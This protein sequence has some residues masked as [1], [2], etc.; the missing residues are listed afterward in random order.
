MK[1]QKMWKNQIKLDD[2][3]KHQKKVWVGIREIGTVEKVGQHKF[4]IVGTHL[5]LGTN[6][7]STYFMSRLIIKNMKKAKQFRWFIETS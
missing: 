6:E 7:T 2:S 4:L 5:L 3:L 1:H